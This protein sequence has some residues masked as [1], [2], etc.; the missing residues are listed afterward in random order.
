MQGV[1]MMS[2]SAAISHFLNCFIGSFP[3]PHA[4]DATDEVSIIFILINKFL[5]RSD[6]NQA[7]PEEG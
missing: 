2:L 7:E 1:D 6:S 5:P 4:Q 3:T